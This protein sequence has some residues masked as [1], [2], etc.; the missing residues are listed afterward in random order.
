MAFQYLK[1]VYRKAGEG[2]FIRACRD[3]VRGNGLKLEEGRFRLDVRK[4]FFTVKV[5][6][7]WNRLP[8]EAVDAPCMEH[9]R[10]GW[11]GL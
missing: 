1:G 10:P 6:R 11:M 3:Q 9:S 7:H 8:S 5:V 4:K 2:L